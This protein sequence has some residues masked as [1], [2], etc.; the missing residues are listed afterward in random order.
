MRRFDFD[1]NTRLADS[2]AVLKNQLAEKHIRNYFGPVSSIYGADQF[3]DRRGIDFYVQ[4][5]CNGMRIRVDAKFKVDRHY[6][7]DVMLE[8]WSNE[9]RKVVGW[10]LNDRSNADYYL[11]AF[12]LDPDIYHMLPAKAVRSAFKRHK[13]EWCDQS[14]SNPYKIV[15]GGTPCGAGQ[16]YHSPSV[17]IP[18][19]VLEAAVIELGVVLKLE[20]SFCER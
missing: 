20:H 3:S 6:Q 17:Y 9:E 1:F 12:C 19:I 18:Y 5:E 16:V 2:R 7:G 8:I 13:D 4:H 11:W 10:S 15:R 14:R